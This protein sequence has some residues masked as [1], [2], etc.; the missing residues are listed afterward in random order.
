MRSESRGYDWRMAD[1]ATA[2][3]RIPRPP[4]FESLIEERRHRKEQLAA[5]FRLF[6]K[7]GFD[8][9]VAG[10]IT[11]RDP[12]RTD[13]FWVNPFGM[14]FS[15]IRVSDLLLV[16]DLGEVVEGDRPGERRG[17]RDPLAGACRALGR[18]RGGARAFDV[19]DE[20]VFARP[21]ARPADA[22]R[23][24]VLR[25]PRLVRRWY[26]YVDAIGALKLL[27]QRNSSI[28]E[29]STGSSRKSTS[30]LCSQN[31]AF[32]ASG[33]PPIVCSFQIPARLDLATNSAPRTCPHPLDGQAQIGSRTG[34]DAAMQRY[35]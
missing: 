8:E 35:L 13:H 27:C 24:R 19:R 14:H 29:S 28:P 2:P 21:S 18:H 9:G 3:V 10:H 22:G 16:N 26:Y 25:R 32:A 23:L 20:L 30:V 31:S 6:A 11:A 12:E 7:F 34:G 15:H 4:V 5:A 17:V 33:L 1:S